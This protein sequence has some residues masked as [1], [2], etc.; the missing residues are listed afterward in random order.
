MAGTD[1]NIRFHDPHAMQLIARQILIQVPGR[2]GTFSV[3]I[4]S[5]SV[6][7]KIGY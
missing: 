1:A 5:L 4:E 2:T 6:M 3:M 7:S